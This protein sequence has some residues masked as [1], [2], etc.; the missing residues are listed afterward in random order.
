[1]SQGVANTVVLYDVDGN[2]VPITVVQIDGQYRIATADDLVHQKL[3]A[4]VLLLSALVEHLK[5]T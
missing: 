1:M 4:L 5:G 2:P 3:D